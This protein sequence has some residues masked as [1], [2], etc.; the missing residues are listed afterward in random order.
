MYSRK[1]FFKS[2]KN[3]LRQPVM[4]ISRSSQCSI[5]LR[6][7]TKFTGKDLCQS[8]FIKKE[9]GTGLFL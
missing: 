1:K 8:L 6:N 2:F 7:S 4:E 9:T 3:F 5:V